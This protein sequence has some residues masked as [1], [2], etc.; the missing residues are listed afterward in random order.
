ML[1]KLIPAL[2]LVMTLTTSQSSLAQTV[3][4][5]CPK[6]RPSKIPG[7]HGQPYQDRE[8]GGCCCGRK[9]NLSPGFSAYW[10]RPLTGLQVVNNKDNYPFDC[11]GPR[12]RDR[13]D[14]LANFKLFPNARCDNGYSGPYCDPFGCLGE[15]YYRG[16][17]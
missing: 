5:C 9:Q 17:K 8:L 10:P 7:L 14:V 11:P 16:E 15:S 4:D 13:M 1:Y 6:P 3:D 12:P 2:I